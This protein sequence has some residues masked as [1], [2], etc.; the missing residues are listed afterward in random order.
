MLHSSA[1]QQ[2]SKE[3]EGKSCM[4]A[5]EASLFWGNSLIAREQTG[6]RNEIYYIGLM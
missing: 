5:E 4:G 1:A 3:M 2:L 6:N